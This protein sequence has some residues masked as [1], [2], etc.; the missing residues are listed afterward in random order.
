[1]GT[2]TTQSDDSTVL[3]SFNESKSEVNVGDVTYE[4]GDVL[5]LDDQ[6]VTVI[7]A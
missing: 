5:V 7:D 2:L 4:E 6:K 3:V 1:M